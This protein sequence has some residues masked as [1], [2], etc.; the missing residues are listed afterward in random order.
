MGPGWLGHGRNLHRPRP[1]GRRESGSAGHAPQDLVGHDQR[2]GSGW[3]PRR[4]GRPWRR[5]SAARRRSRASSRSRRRAGRRRSPRASPRPTR[6]TWRSTRPRRAAR[7]GPWPAAASRVTARAA[8]TSRAI[9]A[10]MK[11]RPCCSASGAPK[12]AALVEVAR[13]RLQRRPGRSRRT[14]RRS[15]SAPRRGPTARSCSPRPP[16]R[17]G[18]RPGTSAP[19]KTSSVAGQAADPHL[20]LVRAEPEAGRPLLDQEGGDRPAPRPGRA[21][22]RPGSARPRARSR[23]RSWCRSAG[24]RAGAS[25]GPTRSAGV[26]IAAA[27]LPACGSVRAKAPSASPG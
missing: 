7:R 2:G 19:S 4:S 12:A 13:G 9:S 22:R 27:S 25:A 20:L 3:C 23:S 6:S 26:R 24:S 11:R 1:P 21:S 17:A 10:S 14:P 8:A 15:R 18:S 16:R 5:A